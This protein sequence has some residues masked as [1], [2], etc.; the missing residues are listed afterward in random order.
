MYIL[1]QWLG[2]H[3]ILDI[4]H[5][6]LT[7]AGCSVS[8]YEIYFGLKIHLRYRIRLHALLTGFGIAGI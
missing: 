7:Q 8:L 5:L 2:L 3:K 1:H 4:S 6:K